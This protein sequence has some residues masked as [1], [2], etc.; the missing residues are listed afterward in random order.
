VSSERDY[1]EKRDFI[2]MGLDCPM[3][4]SVAGQGQSYQGM[5]RDLSSSG[6]LMVT[7]QGFPVGT[8]LEIRVVPGKA[9]VPPLNALVE[10]ARV[11][12]TAPG[13]FELG[14]TIKAFR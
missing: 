8:E 10:V 4:F 2:R 3:T 12:E 13:T 1:Q 6:L 11:R 7:D 9:V 14:V 5:A